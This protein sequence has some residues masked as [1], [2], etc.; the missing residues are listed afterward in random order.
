MK[1]VTLITT[2]LLFC[3]L[4]TACVSANKTESEAPDDLLSDI[5]SLGVDDT[6]N[7]KTSVAGLDIVYVNHSQNGRYVPASVDAQSI[8]E[9]ECEALA[10]DIYDEVL[11]IAQEFYGCPEFLWCQPG[12][13]SLSETIYTEVCVNLAPSENAVII[14]ENNSA[15]LENLVDE[16]FT[17]AL[18]DLAFDLEYPCPIYEDEG[19]LYR[20]EY[21]PGVGEKACDLSAGRILSRENGIVRYGFPIYHMDIETHELSVKPFWAFGYMDFVYE[22]EAWK[23]NDF[24]LSNVF[25]SY[26]EFPG[27]TAPIRMDEFFETTDSL[28]SDNVVANLENGA[29][30]CII[31]DKTVTAELNINSSKVRNIER[32]G[33]NVFVSF[34]GAFEEIETLVISEESG[35]I[36]SQ[37]VSNGYCT[38]DSGNWYYVVIDREN[39]RGDIYDKAN[40]PL[41][42][43][44]A[45]K[46]DTYEYRALP[47]I[48]PIDDISFDDGT[49]TIT[50]DVTAY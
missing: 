35:E 15:F 14:F 21:E 12:Q 31:G 41:R 45:V 46:Q 48:A 32:V 39:L 16:Y 37:F 5:V 22:D 19:I 4:L 47:M 9:E 43:F 3:L 1:K 33:G 6:S 29:V 24:R 23:V 40:N 30:S 44:M 27:G 26:N 38:D 11:A 49:F 50:Y 28:E 10:Y 34:L 2:I 7:N 20:T 42:N 25:Y 8:T 36:I 18:I 13:Y 17:D